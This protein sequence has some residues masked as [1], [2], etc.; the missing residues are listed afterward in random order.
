METRSAPPIRTLAMRSAAWYGATRLWGQLISW[1]VTLLLA[2]LLLPRDYGLF[3]MALSVLSLLEL[4]QEFGLGTALIQRQNLTQE[5]I[6]SVFWVVAG[7]SLVLTAGTFLAAGAISGV[8][9]EPQLAWPLRILSLTFL[10]N[11][12]GMVPYSLM[13]KAINLRQRSLAEACATTASALVALTLASMG[14][15][16]AALV[17]GHLARAVVSCALLTIFSGWLP[18]LAVSRDGV[19]GLLSFGLKVAGSH[20]VGSGSTA[21]GTFVMARMLSSAAVG[22]YSMAESLT[23]AP[24]RLSTA[25]INQVSLPVF[26]KLQHD[27]ESLAA[28]FLKI[29]KFLCVVSLPMQIGLALVAPDLIPLLLSPSWSPMTVPFQILCLQSTMVL[30][31][32]TCSPLLTARGR[33][34]LLFGLSVA[35]FACLVGGVLVGSLFGLVGIAVARLITTLPLRLVM[36]LQTLRELEVTFGT[37]LKTLSAPIGASAVMTAAVLAVRHAWIQPASRIELLTLSIAGGAVTYAVALF[38]LDRTLVPDLKIMARDLRGT[39]NA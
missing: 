11:S 14:W 7:A 33:A 28:H 24:H 16:V 12:L 39:S 37:F 5:Q 9:G 22:L 31:T 1:L 23:E 10:L 15:G 36:L 27:R 13:T 20:L 29:S 18:G 17:L 34:T 8:Y 19:R 38:L 3:A 2:R 32:L 25:V 21:L 35:S 4:L 6:N 30:S 26:A